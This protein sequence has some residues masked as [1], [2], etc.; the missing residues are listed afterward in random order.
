MTWCQIGLYFSFLIVGILLFEWFEIWRGK[1]QVMKNIEELKEEY[2]LKIIRESITGKRYQPNERE[3]QEYKKIFSV[4]PF[5]ANVYLALLEI[6]DGGRPLL[7]GGTE[8]KIIFL[9]TLVDIRFF[10][11]FGWQLTDRR[12]NTKNE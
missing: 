3:K 1:L 11:P 7:P 8:E 6:G 12:Q 5:A 10:N 9:E 2:T 4:C